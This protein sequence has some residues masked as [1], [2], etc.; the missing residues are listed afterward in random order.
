[1][2]NYDNASSLTIVPVGEPNG[3]A[4][5]D[6]RVDARDPRD[7]APSSSVWHASLKRL[8]RDRVGMVSA[9]VVVL[10]F[11]MIL[12]AAFGWIAGDW[13]VERGVSFASPTF[14]GKVE[15]LELG[16]T[17][18]DADATSIPPVDLS[19][20]DPLAPRYKEWA[21]L[22]AKIATAIAP[23]AETL[24]FG[25]D[26]WGHDVLKKAIKGAQVS[27]FVGISAAIVATLIGTMLGAFAGYFRGWIDDVLEWFYSIFTS[28][29]YILLILAFAAVF[30]SNKLLSHAGVAT[31]IAVLA[32]TGWTRVY[33]LMRAEYIKHRSR[34]YVRAA[35][36]IGASNASRM[37]VHI[38]PNASHVILVQMSLLTVEFIKAEVILSFLGLGVPV[39]VVSWGTMLAEAQSELVIGKWWQLFAAGA[40]MAVLV[41]AFSLFTDSLRDALDPKL[42]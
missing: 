36:A 26:K 41:T 3:L 22:T 40:G 5:I 6:D 29:P 31:I 4:I 17:A 23:R 37:F 2:A 1:M 12:G 8:A 33:R 19:D 20:V 21:E 38:L 32:L 25:A 13:Q 34:E 16:T 10:Y 24:P 30:R 18:T 28:I 42:N 35:D 9:A 7:D 27:I 39:D 14:M 15:N 11:L